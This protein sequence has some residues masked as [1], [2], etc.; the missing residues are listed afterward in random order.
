MLQLF[1]DVLP[2]SLAVGIFYTIYRY[3]KVKRHKITF[4]WGTE[5]F[6]V[7][8]LCYVTGLFNLVLVPANFWSYIWF[9]QE[10]GYSAGSLAPLFSGD[11]NFIPTAVKLLMGELTLGKWVLTMLVGNF[12][13]FMPMGFFLP[14]I[15]EKMNH[16]KVL[17]VSVAVPFI[18]EVL[19]PIVGRSF[20]IDDLILNF[21]GILF[22]YLLALCCEYFK[23]RLFK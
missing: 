17:I 20:D 18:V 19:Q 2:I 3:F 16:R 8:F 21:T 4:S 11:F 6:L 10:N 22:G 9:Y 1:L 13:M 23:N 15:F 5:I 7:L 14:F 12:F